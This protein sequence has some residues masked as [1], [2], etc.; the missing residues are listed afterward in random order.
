MGGAVNF[1]QVRQAAES[2]QAEGQKVSVR[3][4]RALLAASKAIVP[5]LLR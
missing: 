5:E 3:A 4:I 2:L 1:K